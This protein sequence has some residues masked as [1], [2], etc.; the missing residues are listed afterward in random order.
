MRSKTFAERLAALEA[1]EH[2]TAR[3]IWMRQYWLGLPLYTYLFLGP[4]REN[5]VTIRDGDFTINDN[6]FY[7]RDDGTPYYLEYAPYAD[8]LNRF[9]GW[10]DLFYTE[11][12][13]SLVRDWLARGV[14]YYGPH[15]YHPTWAPGGATTWRNGLPVYP[16][17]KPGRAG[18][19]GASQWRYD[20][21]MPDWEAH[22]RN[23]SFAVRTMNQSNELALAVVA[24]LRRVGPITTV[25]AMAA[26]LDTARPMVISEE[27]V[28]SIGALYGSALF[29][30]SAL[31]LVG[32]PEDQ[33]EEW[34]AEQGVYEEL[35]EEEYASYTGN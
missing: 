6:L 2:Q 5:K 21:G 3:P 29:V 7:C 12:E 11:A 35:T 10:G 24:A 17:P 13:I 27:M 1:L 23:M 22:Q 16:P 33:P 26:W 15:R 25:E 9:D 18:G 31:R 28:A 4:L 14:L 19:Y 30:Q 8:A 32:I 34:Y 20:F